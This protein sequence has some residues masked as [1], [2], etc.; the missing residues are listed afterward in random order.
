MDAKNNLINI[1]NDK[2]FA[3]PFVNFFSHG[4]MCTHGLLKRSYDQDTNREGLNVK[5]SNSLGMLSALIIGSV[6]GYIP[7]GIAASPTDI[8]NNGPTVKCEAEAGKDI[9]SKKQQAC[10]DLANQQKRA[11]TLKEKSS[12]SS[13]LS[14]SVGKTAKEAGIGLG[15][16]A[17]VGG[18]AYGVYSMLN[19]DDDKKDESSTTTASGGSTQPAGPSTQCD[20]ERCFLWKPKSDNDMRLVI[21]LPPSYN[22][23]SCEVSVEG[24]K[25]LFTGKGNPC[26]TRAESDNRSHYRFSKS[27]ASYCGGAACTAVIK[28]GSETKNYSIPNSGT[29]CDGGY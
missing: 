22:D 23:R 20:K 11:T 16:I 2:R 6:S 25:G 4:I 7:N 18:A 1:E 17:T 28:C 10:T 26:P 24:E 14:G 29:R 13:R 12:G 9:D 21:V 3:V 8:P 19:K 27:G 5:I 15:T